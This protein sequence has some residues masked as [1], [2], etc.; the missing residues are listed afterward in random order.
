MASYIENQPVFLGT[1]NTCSNDVDFVYSQLVDITDTTQFQLSIAPCISAENLIV[2][3]NFEDN[4]DWTLTGNVGIADNQLCFAGDTTTSDV[5]FTSSI[6]TDGDYY[7]VQII[8][9]SVS[10]GSMLV[11]LGST[12]IGSFD[13]IGTYTF[14][15]FATV[16]GVSYPLLI[17]PEVDG[18]ECCI[19][20]VSSFNILTNFIVA[21]YFEDGTFNNEVRYSTDPEY[22][23]FA[24]DTVT[25]DFDWSKFGLEAGCYYFCVLDPCINTNG[26][27]YPPV[28]ANQNF[29]TDADGW[30]LGSSWVY[31]LGQ[32]AVEGTYDVITANNTM[33]Q[34]DVFDSFTN[35]YSV[36][37]NVTNITGTLDVYFGN[38]LVSTIS[39]VGVHTVTGVC[40]VNFRLRLE[41][42]SGTVRVDYVRSVEIDDNDYV[43][44]LTSNM[45]KLDDYSNSCTLLVNAC[46]NED[47]LGFVFD[48]SGFTP[49][50]RLNAKLKEPKYNNEVF[51]YTD[52]KGKKQVYWFTGRKQK[53]FCTDLEPEYVLDYLWSLFGYDNLFIDG[54][55]Y[56]VDEDEFVPQY[57]FDN[58]GSVKF[59]VSKKT[60]DI[61]NTNCSDSENICTLP[62]NYLL[63]TNVVDYVTLV[64]GGKIIIN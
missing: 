33:L 2:N 32:D 56:T 47:G 41:V 21:L 11:Y 61:K 44:D 45:F 1:D 55:L 42:T 37:I 19:S 62:P 24:K 52:S 15:G 14:Y 10:G 3:P 35:S 5:A 23:T 43:C 22:F 28:I 63:R 29:D 12:L 64:D 48:G 49:R 17:T 46:N 8:V 30:S 59:L 53:Y 25:I 27:N 26:Q 39:T 57:S 6:Y 9:D 13:S 54:E 38:N 58:V 34:N 36:T 18:V 51:R 40:T 50:L 31:L 20:T 60:Q 4:S 16:L 7:Q